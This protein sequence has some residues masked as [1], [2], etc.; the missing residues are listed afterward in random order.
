MSRHLSEEVVRASLGLR[1]LEALAANVCRADYEDAEALAEEAA[2][3]EKFMERQVGNSLLGSL[4]K[5]FGEDMSRQATLRREHLYTALVE[6]SS[7]EL[8]KAGVAA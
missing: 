7:A 4:R 8:R 6:I 2:W 5:G 3:V 1:Y